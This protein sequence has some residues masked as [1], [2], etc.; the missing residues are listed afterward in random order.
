MT[1][2]KNSRSLQTDV[3]IGDAAYANS[4]FVIGCIK[5]GY[6]VVS[7]LKKNTRLFSL[8][9]APE[10]SKRGR[11][12]VKGDKLDIANLPDKEFIKFDTGYEDMEAFEGLAYCQS[13]KRVIKL[14]V[15]VISK[16]ERKLFF[17]TDV[18]MSGKDVVDFTDLVS[19]LNLRFAMRTCTLV[20]VTARLGAPQN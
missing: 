16:K 9:E 11:P 19:K 4:S 8:P 20:S 13:L 3:L 14:V 15:A 10:K 1:W 7:R 17:S 18:N 5:R 2:I 12:R 6:K